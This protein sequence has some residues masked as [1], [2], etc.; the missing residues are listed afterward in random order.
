MPRTAGIGMRIPG[1]HWLTILAWSSLVKVK[2]S[3]R[4]SSKNNVDGVLR[5]THEFDV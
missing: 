1:S 3:E 2:S 4:H 5:A